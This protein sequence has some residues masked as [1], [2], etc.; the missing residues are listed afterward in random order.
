MARAGAIEA[1]PTDA[2][3]ILRAGNILLVYPGGD[4]EVFRPWRDRNRIQFA[5]R[6]GFVR[7]ALRAQVPVVPAVSVGAHESLVVV[8]RGE[9]LARMLRLDRTLRVTVMPLS[10]GPP[11]GIAPGGMPTFPLP[12]KITT[13]LCDPIDWTARYGPDAADDEDVV[14]ACYEEITTVMQSVL[15]RLAGERRFPVLG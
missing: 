5:G 9:R 6:R 15:D 10:L 11:F 12:A 4:H 7:L 13:E 8:A 1:G 2:E 3:A 14:T